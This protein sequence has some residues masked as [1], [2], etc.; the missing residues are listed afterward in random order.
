MMRSVLSFL[1]T[2]VF[3]ATPFEQVIHPATDEFGCTP[4]APE[5]GASRDPFGARPF[6]LSQDETAGPEA[7]GGDGYQNLSKA[8]YRR[9]RSSHSEGSDASSASMDGRENVLGVAPLLTG[10]GLLS[11]LVYAAVSLF[12][13]AWTDRNVL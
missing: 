7:T 12:L 5:P 6:V 3:G 2:D 9:H 13:C 4:F 1:S 10:L 11:I 8:A